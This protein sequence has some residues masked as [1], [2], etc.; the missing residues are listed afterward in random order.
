M[1]GHIYYYDPLTLE[2]LGSF[3][4]QREHGT[5]FSAAGEYLYMSD[6][7]GTV[8]EMNRTNGAAT[9]SY[10]ADIA[11]THALPLVFN[12]RI[13]IPLETTLLCLGRYDEEPEISEPAPRTELVFF[14]ALTREKLNGTVTLRQNNIERTYLLQNGSLLIDTDDFSLSILNIE[15]SGYAFAETD[16]QDGER[17]KKS[18]LNP[19]KHNDTLI[20]H[21]IRFAVNSAGL[22]AEALPVLQGIVRLLKIN[23]E[24][25]ASIHGHTDSTGNAAYNHLL[26]ERR[27]GI[28]R[29]FLVKSNIAADRLTVR[30]FGSTQPVADNATE[31][32]RRKNRRT[33]IILHS[34]ERSNP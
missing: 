28:I 5:R 29:D 23:P 14:N 21:D 8:Y 26:S 34:P 24:W 25:S 9:R 27:A 31:E 18:F 17:R 7:A 19:L 16:M 20:L 2:K 10:K 12:G 30:G 33:E 4:H 22:E 6:D 15:K 32:G 13:L 11:Q 1:D 3:R